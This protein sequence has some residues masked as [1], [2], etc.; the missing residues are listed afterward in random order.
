MKKILS[1]NDEKQ[2]KGCRA[3]LSD[4]EAEQDRQGA[5]GKGTKQDIRLIVR[6]CYFTIQKYEIE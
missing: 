6:N 3:L 1:V 2:K 4:R 5:K